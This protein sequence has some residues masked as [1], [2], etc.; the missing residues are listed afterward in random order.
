MQLQAA[1]AQ[2]RQLAVARPQIGIT[3]LQ[4]TSAPQR[5][6]RRSAMRQ[7]VT[8]SAAPAAGEAASTKVVE[9]G[10]PRTAVVGVLGGGQLGKM[11]GQEAVSV[12]R[13]RAAA[14]SSAGMP[15][16][17]CCTAS[18]H[19]VH[20]LS[21]PACSWRALGGVPSHSARSP[22]AACPNSP[23]LFETPWLLLRQR[24]G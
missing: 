20:H 7:G 18:R 9:S 17:R 10:L 1:I 8:C 22:P 21:A 14:N 3:S 24:W 23:P 11:M 19:A 4:A 6:A 2:P 12:G 5:H 16:W 15:T 13:R